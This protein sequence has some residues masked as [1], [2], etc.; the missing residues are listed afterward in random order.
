MF[1]FYGTPSILL[2]LFPAGKVFQTYTISFEYISI[3]IEITTGKL[4][5]RNPLFKETDE[6]EKG[7]K[8]LSFF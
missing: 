7:L 3:N 8:T 5:E 4:L 6:L 1:P 2:I